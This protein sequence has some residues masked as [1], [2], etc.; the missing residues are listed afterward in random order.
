VE[1]AESLARVLFFS[2]PSFFS[3]CY[4]FDLVGIIRLYPLSLL[5][6]FIVTI[7]Y[8]DRF[9]LRLLNS[10]TLNRDSGMLC[11]LIVRLNES[12][13]FIDSGILC[14]LIVRLNEP[15]FYMV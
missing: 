6:S 14:L 5:G 15:A 4:L 3:A 11:L 13:F 1:R 10:L 12:A 8:A 7:F 9:E 2:A